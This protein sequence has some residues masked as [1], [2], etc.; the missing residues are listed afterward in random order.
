MN[1][2]LLSL[3]LNLS[4]LLFSLGELI[5]DFTFVLKIFVFM[6]IFSFA[7]NHV[8]GGPIAIAVI[9]IFSYFV[10][11]VFWPLFGTLYLLYMLGMI[12]LAG[13]FIDFFFVVPGGPAAQG[14]K[15]SQMTSGV[16][17]AKR[18]AMMQRARRPPMG[19]GG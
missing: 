18:M 4:T 6:A 2:A 9:L 5:G 8:G 12:G 19:P 14:Q 10:L 17:V 15:L 11:F 13:V 1:L 3:G 7:K 16:D